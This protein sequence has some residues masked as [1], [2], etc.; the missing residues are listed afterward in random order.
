MI[1]TI[2]SALRGLAKAVSEV[3]SYL[4]LSRLMNAGRAEV[5]NELNAKA[6]DDRAVAAEIDAQPDITDPHELLASLR[7]D[8][9]DRADPGVGETD[10]AP[11]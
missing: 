10:Q 3:F 7:A 11:G 4:Q 6:A 1:A 9:S 5:A 8:D 2:L